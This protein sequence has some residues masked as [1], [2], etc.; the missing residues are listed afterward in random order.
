MVRSCQIDVV[1]VSLFFS[2]FLCFVSFLLLEF[3]F[4]ARCI[5][6]GCEPLLWHSYAVASY[7][8]GE[9]CWDYPCTAA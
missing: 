6:I 3:E 9:E 8:S 5:G 7:F 2:W 4:Q 1:L